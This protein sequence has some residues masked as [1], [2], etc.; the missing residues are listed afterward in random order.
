[1]NAP[2]PWFIL[3]EGGFVRFEAWDKAKPTKTKGHDE[4]RPASRG[5]F[6]T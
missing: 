5:I 2:P 6:S 4:R 3:I 1:V